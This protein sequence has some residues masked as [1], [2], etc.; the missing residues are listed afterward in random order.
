VLVALLVIV[1][2]SG[3]AHLGPWQQGG[4]ASRHW[5][6]DGAACD[7]YFFMLGLGF[8]FVEIPLAQ[9]FILFLDQPVTALAVVIFALLFTSGIGSATAPRWRL[10]AALGML[11]AA[12]LLAPLAFRAI[13]ATALGL[14]LGARIVIAIIS[15]A[16]LGL[17][18]GIP[19][20]RG[21][22]L[23]ERAAPG[24]TPWAW[25]INGSAS[26]ISG[27]LAVMIALSAGFSAVLW[28]GA[29]C[30]A[31]A[32]AAIWPILRPVG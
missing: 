19:F 28:I 25:A 1:T 11:I 16:P 2:I 8:L 6:A 17:L 9:H 14:P 32:L 10:D 24:L 23:I 15:I 13:F 30:Y 5:R 7:A 29:A 27:V 18:M 31:V 12:A 3:G 4:A 26:V 20:A 22:G 21:M